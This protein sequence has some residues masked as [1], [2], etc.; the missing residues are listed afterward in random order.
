[1]PRLLG[2]PMAYGHPVRIAHISDCYLPRTGGIETQVRALA[3]RQAAMGMDVRVV[4][5]TADTQMRPDGIPV[6][7]CSMRVPFN[8]PIH[9]RT[10]AAVRAVLER[11]PVDVVHLHA[12]VISPFAWGA[13]RAVRQL[14]I[15][16]LV[17]VHSVWGGLARP[18]FGASDAL[19]HWSGTGLQLSA[20][21]E[22]AADRVR[23]AVPRAGDVLVIPNGIDPMMWQIDRIPGRSDLLRLV[24]VM[25]LAPRKRLMPLLR[26]VRRAQD[27]LGGRPKLRLVVVGDGPERERAERFAGESVHF[28]GRLDR[29]GIR[30]QLAEAD[31][32]VQPSVHESFGIAAL[33]ARTAGLPVL[34]RSQAG[35]AQFIRDGVEG[36]LVDA[37]QQMVDAIVQLA[38]DRER[39]NRISAHNAATPPDQTWDA[40]LGLAQAGYEAAIKRAGGPKVWR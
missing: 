12:G 35:T 6:H 23:Q 10:R 1:M 18:G 31:L 37:D 33:E 21:S 2:V 19:L 11:E 38:R 16:A 4:T 15:P 25:R 14:G 8:L 17:T 3:V 40:V 7:R 30:E 27:S 39:L 28:T 24:S 32:Y 9:L 20:V 26:M 5:A 22:L 29:D 36:I 34:A 13:L